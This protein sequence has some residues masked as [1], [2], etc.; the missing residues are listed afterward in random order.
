[1]RNFH[2]NNQKEQNL[3]KTKQFWQH[4]DIKTTYYHNKRLLLGI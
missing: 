4:A 3:F 1:M 2:E